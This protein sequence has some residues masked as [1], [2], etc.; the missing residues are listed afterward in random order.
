MG[1]S[2]RRERGETEWGL[3]LRYVRLS[4]QDGAETLQ[5]AQKKLPLNIK[6]KCPQCRYS[7]TQSN[8]LQGAA[9]AAAAKPQM[10]TD[11]PAL[12][13]AP[14]HLPPPLLGDTPKWEGQRGPSAW[15]RLHSRSSPQVSAASLDNKCF[16]FFLCV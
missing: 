2:G 1:P 7:R 13:P 14:S 9:S 8:I 11:V 12:C 3:Q 15:T 5:K 16:G 6:T 4:L 10:A